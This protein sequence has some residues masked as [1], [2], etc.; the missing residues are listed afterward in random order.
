MRKGL[1]DKEVEEEIDRLRDSEFVRLAQA[2]RRDQ[3]R[4]RQYLYQLRCMEK[5]G[6]ELAEAGMTVEMYRKRAEEY[7]EYDNE[8]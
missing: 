6:R 7:E 2:E 3:C 4:R 1:T 8:E 5:H